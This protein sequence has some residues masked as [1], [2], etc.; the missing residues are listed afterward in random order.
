[1]NHVPYLVQQD[2]SI[3]IGTSTLAEGCGL[4][5]TFG[6][7]YMVIL[8]CLE[9][10]ARFTVNFKD[11][12]LR[13]N[14]FLVLSEDSIALLKKRSNEFKVFFC[15]MPKNLS[16]EIAYQLPNSLFIFLH[17]QPHCISTGKDSILL[18]GWIEQMYDVD[19]NSH[20][21][22][23]IIQRNLLQNFFLR[24]AERTTSISPNNI[25]FGRGEML[26]WKFW[27]L[28]GQNSAKHR[29]V[30][31]Y[32]QKLC[33]TPFYLSQL[34]KKF[35]NESPKNLIDR[36]VIL[37][38]KSLLIYSNLSI[39]QIAEKL[40]FEDA[41]YLCRYFKRQTGVSLSDFRKQRH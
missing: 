29:D 10:Y 11:R 27:D 31:F 36:Q 40:Y 37:E 8:V 23:R 26:S 6:S 21:Y 7:A 39:G 24:I 35:F 17:N 16:T 9:G 5:L 19:R 1:M 15:L 33:I 41:S 38:I 4:P 13:K 18:S 34:T 12:A 22:K 28:I 25:E 32:A 3:Q 14:H 2:D 20:D 30:K